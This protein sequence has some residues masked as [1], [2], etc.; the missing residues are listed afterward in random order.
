METKS[1]KRL[2]KI[3]SI[4]AA[5]ILTA[6]VACAVYYGVKSGED[7]IT[8]TVSSAD[9]TADGVNT[10]D[11]EPS[12][13]PDITV[14]KE[15]KKLVKKKSPTS[16]VTF[17]KV[18]KHY[19]NFR[20]YKVQIQHEGDLENHVLCIYAHSAHAYLYFYESYDKADES[21]QEFI[22]EGINSLKE[23]YQKYENDARRKIQDGETDKIY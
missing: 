11:R 2:I 15:F 8:T 12:A 13:E 16:S 23:N 9:V 3:S 6:L 20:F 19:K 4:I 18:N 10:I 7:K 21:Q 14:E 5:V 1:D 17:F 22:D